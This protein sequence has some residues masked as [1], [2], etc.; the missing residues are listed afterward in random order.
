MRGGDTVTELTGVLHYQFGE[1]MLEPTEEVVFQSENPRPE[2]P[3][4]QPGT[5]SVATMNVLNFFTTLDDSG[6]ICGPAANQDCRGADNADEFTRQRDKIIAA[7]SAMDADVVGLVEMENSADNAALQSIIDGLNASC[8]R[9]AAGTYAFIETG[10]IGT[11]AI[12]VGFIYKTDTVEP[13]GDFA[14]LDSSVDPNFIDTKNRPALAQTFMEK[15][16]GEKFT[17]AINHFKSKGSACDDVSDPNLN[18]GAGNCNLTRQKAAQALADWL[19]T[20][21]T[22]SGDPDYLILGDLN[23]YRNETPITAL[24]AAGYTDLA[25]KFTGDSAYSFVFGGEWGYLDYALAKLN[26]AHAGR[27]SE[28][29]AH[30][31]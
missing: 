24:E 16:S 15:A 30:Q 28:R 23:A 25:E 8:D 9:C 1:Y 18:D 26:A 17:A 20:D 10:A 19:A 2:P 4:K 27:Q 13:V 7:L 12:R 11:D 14:V 22:S 3:T 5:L 31:R 29:M 6:A 21:P